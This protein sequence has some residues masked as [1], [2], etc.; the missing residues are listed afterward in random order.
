M[1]LIA[2]FQMTSEQLPL[3]DVA[4]GVSEATIEFESVQGR[5]SGAPTFIV[6]I[7]GA[8]A[9]AIEAAFADADSV[10]DHSLVVA[11]EAT[12]HYRCR[13]TGD[14][15]TDLELLADNGSIPDRVL[16]TPSGWEE[17][18]WFAD[19]EEFNQFR[20]FCRANDY[21]IR[22]DRLVETDEGSAGSSTGPFG[23]GDRSWPR[24]MTDAQREALVTAHEMGYFDMPRTAT[25]ADVADEL[26]VSSASLSE[27]LRRAQNHLIAG[28]RRTSSKKPRTN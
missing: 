2:E 5:P 1:G 27:R 14:P 17:R 19:R 13:P 16:A 18:R 8:D 23:T 28:F 10:T 11:D 21:E 22:L 20:T 26:G 3:V 6:R 4:A 12:R 24:E 9:D 25:M 7:V 15:P